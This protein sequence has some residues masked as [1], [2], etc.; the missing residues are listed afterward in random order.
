MKLATT[1]NKNEQQE[2]AKNNAELLTIWMT[3]TWKTFE[4]TIRRSHSR[5]IKA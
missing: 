5:S 4:E 3:V 2:D 1:H